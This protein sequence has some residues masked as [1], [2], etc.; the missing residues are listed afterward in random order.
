MI[1]Q[2]QRAILDF[3]DNRM[4]E[5]AE[6]IYE[7]QFVEAIDIINDNMDKGPVRDLVVQAIRDIDAKE[8]GNNV[9]LKKSL[10]SIYALIGVR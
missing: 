10:D 9:D 8:L 6:E 4:D 5:L 7:D 1:N 3:V 2:T